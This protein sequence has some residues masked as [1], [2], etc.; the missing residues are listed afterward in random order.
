M[1]KGRNITSKTTHTLTLWLGIGNQPENLTLLIIP[2]HTQPTPAPPFPIEGELICYC[3]CVLEG[4]VRDH[5]PQPHVPPPR[6][7]QED[8]H[9]GL[10][11][12]SCAQVFVAVCPTHAF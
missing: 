4:W 5:V 3:K 2:T 1:T 12:S 10:H 11:A 6:W 8:T 7:S 9:D